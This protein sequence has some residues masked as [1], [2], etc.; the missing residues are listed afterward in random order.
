MEPYDETTHEHCLP[1]PT[2]SGAPT[3]RRGA[4]TCLLRGPDRCRSPRDRMPFES[5]QE[6]SNSVSMTLR[7]K[8]LIDIGHHVIGCRYDS[9]DEGL[10]TWRAISGS[11]YLPSGSTRPSD[12]SN[13]DNAPA[14]S[15]GSR[16]SGT[17]AARRPLPLLPLLLASREGS[18]SRGFT[19][20]P[21][22]AQLTL[23]SPLS[24]QLKPTCV[25]T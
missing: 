19:L 22:S 21:I 16:V 11:P 5:R 13:P 23:T 3:G 14:I 9:T 7:A 24:A 6:G 25:P 12:R 1:G 18:H 17:S 20:V 15:S 8:G 4:D 2:A 10:K